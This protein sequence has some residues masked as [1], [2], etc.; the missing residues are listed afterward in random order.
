MFKALLISILSLFI[1]SCKTQK[2][3]VETKTTETETT[4]RFE[5]EIPRDTT[6]KTESEE[7]SFV[8]ALKVDSS[9]AISVVP[10]KVESGSNALQAPEVIIKNN[11]VYVDC[12]KDAEELF[13]EWK[14]KFIR[15]H[16]T[17]TIEKEIPVLVKE[18]LSKWELTQIWLGRIFMFLITSSGVGLILYKFKSKK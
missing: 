4:S 11:T 13:F 9:G 18:D 6:L 17:T 15:E 10:T 2:Q 16:K 7:S 5:K 1:L 12:Q 14:E 3:I 8:G